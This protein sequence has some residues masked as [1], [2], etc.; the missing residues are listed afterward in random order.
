[1]F[2][3]GSFAFGKCA[4]RKNS[5]AEPSLLQGCP[6]FLAACVLRVGQAG[7]FLW[8]SLEQGSPLVLLSTHKTLLDG[9]LLP[10]VLLSQGLG[11]LRVAWD[12][13]ACSP[14]LRALL[15][16]L[17]GLFLPSEA[18]LSLDSSE[19][20]LARAVVQEVID[21]LL[22]SGQPL[23]I[24]LEEPPGALGPRLS[25]LGQ[26]WLGFVVRAVQVGIIP[27][28][29]LVPVAVTYDV[30]P[31]APCDIYHASAPL[32]LWTGALA[33]LRSLCSHLGCSRQICSRVHL[34]QPFSLQ[35]Y[36]I[37]A[38]SC[39]GSRQTL[40]QLLQ[41]ILLGQCTAVPDTEKEQEWTPITGPLLA[42]KEEDQL[43][44]RRLSHHVLSG[45]DEPDLGLWGWV[46]ELSPLSGSASFQGPSFQ[47]SV[48]T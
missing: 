18:N 29:L 17:G 1:K 32:G 14:S 39:W 12:S 9:I 20:L 25:A 15:R 33:V 19:G 35:E 42:L 3:K 41:P 30:V 5:S 11:V 6:G 7:T 37:S 4:Q 28:A 47:V 2:W 40:E 24:F 44:V 27:D 23:L 31:D 46:P 16:K 45:E 43:L 21:Q 36:T 48:C 34:A 26:A 13:R 10:F 38:R 22:V 8:L